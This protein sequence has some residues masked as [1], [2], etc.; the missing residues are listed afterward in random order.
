MKYLPSD[1]IGL[2]LAGSVAACFASPFL[3]GQGSPP[4]N[5]PLAMWRETSPG[6]SSNAALA[7]YRLRSSSTAPSVLNPRLQP[8]AKNQQ[9]T[10]Y[11]PSATRGRGQQGIASSST[12]RPGYGLTPTRYA[13]GKPFEGIR[14][15]PTA[16]ERYWPLLLEGRQ[17]PH[18]GVIIW[19]LP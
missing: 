8:G 10:G 18:T 13:T 1:L 5:D 17:D 11:Y 15:A 16:F 9:S 14:P 19:S 7:F 3:Y 12:G 6:L 2:I 4:G